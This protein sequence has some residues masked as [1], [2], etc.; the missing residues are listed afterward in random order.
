MFYKPILALLIVVTVILSSC[1][2]D[3]RPYDYYG[4][5][6]VWGFK[7]IYG[8]DSIAKKISYSTTVRKAASPGNIYAYKNYIFQIE[9]GM[10]IHVLDN[11]VPDSAKRIGFIDVMGCSQLSI[12]DDKIYIN[13]YND[14]VALQFSPG[15]VKEYSRLRNVF[16]EFRVEPPSRGYYECVVQG[17]FVIGWTQDSLIYRCYKN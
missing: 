10:G 4:N 1:H 15:N 9:I 7:P 8:P 2:P 14:L 13:N 11:T 6:K 5:T 3:R 16:T 12:K 17:G